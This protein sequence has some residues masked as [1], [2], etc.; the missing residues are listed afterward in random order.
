MANALIP[1][2]SGAT[3][4]TLQLPPKQPD[5]KYFGLEPAMWA[6]VVTGFAVVVTSCITL[7]VT[8]IGV[9]AQNR[10]TK[11]ELDEART[12][13]HTDRVANARREIYGE[14]MADF[15]KVQAFLGGMAGEGYQPSDGLILS[16]MSASVNKLWIWGEVEAAYAAREFYSQVNEFYHEALAKA[17]AIYKTR[18]L[19]SA[20][21]ASEAKHRADLTVL[22]TERREH[23]D[24]PEGE[25]DDAW[26]RKATRLDNEDRL[27]AAS[28]V[29]Q[30]RAWS[31]MQFAVSI[32]TDE[33]LDFIISRQTSLMDQINVVM[34][35][36]RADVGLGGDI[37][38][39]NQQ[40]HQMSERATAAVKKLK[41]DHEA[42][43]AA[44]QQ[45]SR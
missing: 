37:E 16:I 31:G 10:K 28:A 38:K 4:I 29:Q 2:P 44:I 33:Y 43:M 22:A 24:R 20:L 11:R 25:R 40:S 35:L 27:A 32:K 34:A 18:N 13:A 42:E 1:L 5:D 19:I 12:K 39:L 45:L 9:T 30:R 41:E 8:W 7:L 21:K 26:Q 3:A 23:W 15:Q 14:V 6:P 36:A 17:L